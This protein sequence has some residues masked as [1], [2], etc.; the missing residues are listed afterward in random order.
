MYSDPVFKRKGIHLKD[1]TGQRFG[2]LTVTGFAFKERL[3][4]VAPPRKTPCWQYY[5]N[6]VCDC[7]SSKT[8]TLSVSN[9]KVAKSCGCAHP[10]TKHGMFKH[11][12]YNTWHSMIERC[13][14][15]KVRDY[16]RYG[17]RG[18]KVCDRWMSFE[19]F[20]ADVGQTWQKGLTIDRED[21]DKNYEPGNCKWSTPLQQAHN[22]CDNRIIPTP[23]GPMNVTQAAKACGIPRNTIYARILYGWKDEDLL[24][25]VGEY[26]DDEGKFTHA[27]GRTGP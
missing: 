9:L 10:R 27:R 14:N 11:P 12:A 3:K 22:R 18:I 25:P 2:I 16:H 8:V 1:L 21:N 17:G 5:W 24:L 26:R 23:H 7:D 4:S 20:W 15:P 6:C 13:R 19:N